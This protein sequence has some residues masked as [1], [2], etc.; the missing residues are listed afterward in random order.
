MPR[1]HRPQLGALRAAFR[2]RGPGGCGLDDDADFVFASKGAVP[3]G[4]GGARHF[5]TIGPEAG[6][7]IGGTVRLG[8]LSAT[9]KDPSHGEGARGTSG[10]RGG[11]LLAHLGLGTAA[12]LHGAPEKESDD[13]NKGETREGAEDN[14]DDVDC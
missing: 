6:V 11:E 14:A 1:R 8:G 9:G 4:R 10:T 13:Q 7:G 3:G 2:A 12:A 5:G